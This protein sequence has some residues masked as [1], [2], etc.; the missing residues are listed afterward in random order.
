MVKKEYSEDKRE[1]PRYYM[2]LAIQAIK[3]SVDELCTSGKLFW[4]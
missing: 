4:V 3:K 1:A 2:E